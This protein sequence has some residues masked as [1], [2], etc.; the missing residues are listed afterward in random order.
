MSKISSLT[1]L[2]V[3]GLGLAAIYAADAEA[4]GRHDRAGG[5]AELSFAELDADGDGQIT[6]GD[7][8]A[9]RT[10][11]F[12]E[13]DADGDGQVSLEEFVARAQADA[14]ARAT[15]L[16]ERLDVDGD[17]ALSQDALQAL[18]SG[19]RFD[20]MLSRIDTDGDGGISEEEFEAAQER[21]AEMR[22]RRGFGRWGGARHQ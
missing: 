18:R 3:L 20:R 4:K 17:G 11:R 6:E 7:I 9:L 21:F 19:P 13:V 15:E 12:A 1:A 8:D 14:E 10:A 16:F 22:D 5:F 2:A